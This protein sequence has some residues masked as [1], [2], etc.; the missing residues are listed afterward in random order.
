MIL[1]TLLRF[2]LLLLHT[3][4]FPSSFAWVF[5]SA[6]NSQCKVLRIGVIYAGAKYLYAIALNSVAVAG[7][8]NPWT[9]SIKM[10]YE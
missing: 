6:S 3:Q 5:A 2:L 7:G 9:S 1:Q 10:K 8:H 4:Y